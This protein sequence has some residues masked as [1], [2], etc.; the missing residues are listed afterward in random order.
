[1]YNRQDFWVTSSNKQLVFV[2]HINTILKSTGVAAV[3]VPNN[4]LFEGE[5]GKTIHKKPLSAYRNLFRKESGRE[6]EKI[7]RSGD[8]GTR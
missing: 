3:V 4:V 6:M 7:F 8:I 2:Q 1:M 5:A